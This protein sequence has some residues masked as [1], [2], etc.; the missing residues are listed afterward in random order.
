VPKK[1]APQEQPPGDEPQFEF[2]PLPGTKPAPKKST[3]KSKPAPPAEE[4]PAAPPK[5]KEKSPSKKS[6]AKKEPGKNEPGTKELTKKK[7]KL[8]KEVLPDFDM[9]ADVCR[10]CCGTGHIPLRPR[11]PYYHVEGQPAPNAAAA[12]PWRW[13]PKCSGDHEAS[14]FVEVETERIKDIKRTNQLWEE[15]AGYKFARVESRHFTIHCDLSTPEMVHKQGQAAEAVI[16][17]IQQQSQTVFLTPTRPNTAELVLVWDKPKYIKMIEIC[18]PIDEFKGVSDWNLIA[19][20][21]GFA[22]RLTRI[23]NANQAKSAPPEHMTISEVALRQM[24]VA[25]QGKDK[26]WLG[27]GFTYHCESAV[28]NKV[29]IHYIDYQVNETRLGDNWT[30]EAR[31]YLSQGKLR[32]W[33]EMF[34]W[35]LRNWEARDHLSAY[36]M[37]SYLFRSAPKRFVSMVMAIRNGAD[38]VEAMETAYGRKVADLERAAAQWISSL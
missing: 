37:V 11:T 35:E 18:Q 30:N 34:A 8:G 28:T 6:P 3:P 24:S 38:D 20:C 7:P 19:Q 29:L 1:S 2:E 32:K 12:V 22:G 27:L 21:G 9:P 10:T 36:A 33:N 16:A 23:S 25:A 26:D 17:Y 31:K 14:E 13:C 4:E 5:G 15:R